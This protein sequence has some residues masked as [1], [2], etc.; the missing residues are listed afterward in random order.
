MD[1]LMNRITDRLDRY[2]AGFMVLLMGVLVCVVVWQVFARYLLGAPSSV[3]EEIARFLLIWIGLM[4]SAYAYRQNLHL[5]FDY[6]SMKLTGLKRYWL[7]IAIHVL[8]ALFSV[9]VLVLGG[10]YLVNITWELRQS[11]AALGIPMAIVYL[12]LPLSGLFILLYAIQF[13]RE[14]AAGETTIDAD[15]REEGI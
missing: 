10:S 2:L 15:H 9:L 4:G 13:V 5:A 14:R 1:N 8:I 3:T 7:E 11:S 12:S 6:F